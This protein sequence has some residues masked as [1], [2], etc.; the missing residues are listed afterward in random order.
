MRNLYRPSAF[1]DKVMRCDF[2]LYSYLQL[3]E[4]DAILECGE[5]VAAFQSCPKRRHARRTPNLFKPFRSHSFANRYIRLCS[6][7]R[8]ASLISVNARE[9]DRCRAVIDMDFL[10]EIAADY[11][12]DTGRK[13]LTLR[14]AEVCEHPIEGNRAGLAASGQR[15]LCAA[16]Q[17]RR[18]K[19]SNNV[20]CE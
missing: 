17:K 20:K 13:P 8:V 10:T 2:S 18:G 11:S 3:G 9:V 4:T 7:K 1:S 19:A 6:E 15:T 5:R 12:P 16:R 14:R